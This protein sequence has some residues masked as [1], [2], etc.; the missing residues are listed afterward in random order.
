MPAA[1]AAARPACARSFPTCRNRLGSCAEDGVL[2]PVVGVVGALQAQ[3]ALAVRVGLCAHSPLGRLVSFDAGTFRFGG[4]RFD[5]APEPAQGA[6]FIAPAA[7]REGDFV[8]DLR[9]PDEGPL[10]HPAARRLSVDG[11]RP[12]RPAPR[13]RPARRA[14]LPLGPALLAGGRP[15]RRRLGRRNRASSPL[16]TAPHR[17]PYRGAGPRWRDCTKLPLSPPCCWPP[18]RVRP[19]AAGQ[20]DGDAGLVREPR[21]RPDRR[22]RSRRAISPTLGWR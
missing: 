4:F 21:S 9:A 12:R 17:N 18:P 14:V 7:M 11:L 2:G 20:A 19:A 1:S 5:G 22:C 16:A 3:M 8:V 13:A 10:P 15:A 6:R